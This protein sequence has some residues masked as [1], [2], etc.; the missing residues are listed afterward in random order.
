MKKATIA[1]IVIY[2]GLLVQ[3]GVP[4][5]AAGEPEPWHT[6][7]EAVCT[8]TQNAMAFTPKQLRELVGR[9]DALVPQ[10]EKLD[11]TRRKVFLKRLRQCRGVFVYV[12][13]SKNNNHK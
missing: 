12:L 3:A 10:I 1:T 5:K 9:C 6:E 11:E 4:A 7:F 8:Q 2:L 13:E